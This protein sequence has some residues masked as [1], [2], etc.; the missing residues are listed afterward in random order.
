MGQ[1]ETVPVLTARGV[2]YGTVQGIG[3][4]SPEHQG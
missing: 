2:R 4:A 3:E 1:D